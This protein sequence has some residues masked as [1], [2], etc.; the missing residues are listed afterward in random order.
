MLVVAMQI[1]LLE[2]TMLPEA[3]T[4]GVET[5]QTPLVEAMMLAEMQ[6][7]KGETLVQKVVKMP[8][9]MQELKVVTMPLA[10]LHLIQ[11]ST[12]TPKAIQSLSTTST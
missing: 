11:P 1:H 10:N 5:T 7:L 3:T 2:E 12:L 8:H 6:E 9:Q 4:Q